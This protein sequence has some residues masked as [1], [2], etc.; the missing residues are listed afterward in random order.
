MRSDG[1]MAAT[2]AISLLQVIGVVFGGPLL[3][4]LMRTVRCRLEGRVGPPVR[5]PL[6]E[7]RKLAR[8]Q[9]MRPQRASWIFPLAPLVLVATT[10]LVA[11]VAP[12]L[13]TDPA[14]GG[15]A[16]LFAVVYL[17]LLGSVAL[18]LGALDTG[19]AFGG[20]GASRALTIGAVAEPAL[21]VS[22]LA[23]SVP[24][25]SSNLPTI[26]ATSLA[27]PVLLTTPQR[28]LALAAFV[29]VV[30]AECGRLPVDNP[31]THLELTMIHEAMVLEYSGTDLALVRLGESMRLV[32]LLALLAVLFVPWGIATGH[33]PAAQAVALVTLV[34]KVALLGTALAALEVAM[35][36]LRLFRVPEL[37][38]GGFVLS[39]LAVV[40][41]LVLA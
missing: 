17:L 32:V 4:G 12:L 23:L 39:V 8:R 31:G 37:M 26:I 27:H 3:V 33:G 30:V 11:A 9:R 2:A 22:I 7:L 35:A 40:S 25:H 18:G 13:T 21:L 28:L 41:A 6:L 14:M 38:A 15:T 34:A 16:D 5:Q 36:K 1:S 10:V 20:M 29:I 19:T 24:A